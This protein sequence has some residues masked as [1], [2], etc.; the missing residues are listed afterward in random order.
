MLSEENDT[1]A[2]EFFTR[3]NNGLQEVQYVGPRKAGE[4]GLIGDLGPEIIRVLFETIIECF[5]LNTNF[6][7][8]SNMRGM[9]VIQQSILDSRFRRE[10]FDSNKEWRKAQGWKISDALVKASSVG[11]IEEMEQFVGYL[12]DSTRGITR[13]ADLV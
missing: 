1:I 10:L 12:R 5:G 8:A 7:I 13:H 3:L 4:Q 9:N 11:T 6:Q 2:S